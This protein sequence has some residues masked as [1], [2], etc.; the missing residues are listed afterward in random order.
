[1]RRALFLDR[2]GIVNVDRHYVYRPEDFEFV[3]GI[4]DLCRDMQA[5]GYAPVVVTNQAG[6]GRGYYSEADFHRLTDWMLARFGDAG[7]RVEGVYFCPYHPEHGVGAYRQESA[8]RKPNPGMLLQARDELGVNL[9][10]SLLIGDKES[11]IE[12]AQRA[13][14]GMSILVAHDAPQSTSRAQLRFE[15]VAATGAW[16]RQAIQMP[17]THFFEKG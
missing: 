7:V 2:D 3:E 1:M 17:P 12:A 8:C 9:A 4:F 10:D 5:L 16:I 6:I 13:G 14:V 11:D 15:S